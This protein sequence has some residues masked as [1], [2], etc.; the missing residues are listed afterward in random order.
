M[1][2]SAGPRTKCSI[3]WCGGS[4]RVQ[5]A[6]EGW[7]WSAWESRASQVTSRCRV[8]LRDLHGARGQRRRRR[9]PTPR[10]RLRPLRPRRPRPFGRARTGRKSPLHAIDD[11]TA[12]RLVRR[13]AIGTGHTPRY[14]PTSHLVE[15]D[16]SLR[17]TS[18]STQPLP[19]IEGFDVTDPI[20]TAVSRF[21]TQARRY[22]PRRL[23]I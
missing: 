16:P 23:T 11:H 9:C 2:A 3:R 7:R 18:G 20:G 5:R 19:P 6:A 8:I 1:G 21:M 17:S 12:G 14:I 13:L 15:R 4:V 10:S 22:V